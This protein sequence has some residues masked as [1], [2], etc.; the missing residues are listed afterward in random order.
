MNLLSIKQLVDYLQP[1]SLTEATRK[2]IQQ[3]IIGYELKD[4]FLNGHAVPVAKYSVMIGKRIG[5]SKRELHLLR[6]AALVHDIGKIFLDPELLQVPHDKLSDQDIALLKLHP[7]YGAEMLTAIPELHAL[8]PAVYAHHE[9]YD[10]H[11]YP[12]G[13][14]GNKIPLAARIIHIAD[15]YHAMTSNV[16]Y[17]TGMS[18]AEAQQKLREDHSKRWDPFLVKVFLEA[19]SKKTSSNII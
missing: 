10:G 9:D 15:N 7:E 1:I 16:V 2:K 17:Q 11:G 18:T 5:L 6:L 8:I 3:W 13:K 14:A 4:K 12:V 19:I